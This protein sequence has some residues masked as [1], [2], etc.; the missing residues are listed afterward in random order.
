M[1]AGARVRHAESSRAKRAV[2]DALVARAVERHHCVRAAAAT[3]EVVLRAAQIADP[4]FAGRRDKLDGMNGSDACAVDL[5]GECE[6]DG[7]AATVVVDARP[8]ETSTVAADREIG[9]AR[10]YRVEVGTDGNG[11]QVGDS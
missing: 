6:H 7:Q 9:L 11:R 1:S 5:A 2:D 8:D 3:C 10:K 4:L